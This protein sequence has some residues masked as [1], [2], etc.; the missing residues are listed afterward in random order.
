[1]LQVQ[2]IQLNAKLSSTRR[3]V[4]MF[5]AGLNDHID[6]PW[7]LETMAKH[8]NLGRSRFA[9]YCKTITNMTA[10]EYLNH[11]RIEKA[12]YLLTTESP[13]NNIL[14]IA[15]KCGFESSQYFATVFK[16]KVGITPSHY[17]DS[18]KSLCTLL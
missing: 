2:N 18:K 17:R 13:S 4:E 11:C 3:S 6:Y 8:C 5:L 14:D 10:A 15:M 12:K 1:M 7:T 9:H 16:K